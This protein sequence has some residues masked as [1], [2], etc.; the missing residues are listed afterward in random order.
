M[1]KYQNPVKGTSR[2]D[3]QAAN[4]GVDRD[5]F[6]R[7]V[8]LVLASVHLGPNLHEYYPWCKFDIG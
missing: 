5:L 7:I 8:L 2:S 6:G 1:E 4:F 3:A